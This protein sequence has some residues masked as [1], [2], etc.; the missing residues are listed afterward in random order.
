MLNVA[1]VGLGHYGQRLVESVNG[2]SQRVRVTHAVAPRPEKARDFAAAMGVSL[3]SDYA[4]VLADPSIAGVVSC[5][6]AHLHALHSLQAL[7][8]GKHVLGV[9]PMALAG[10]DARALQ[11]AAQARG[12]VMALGY[13]RC[14]MPNVARLREEIAAGALGELLHAQGSFCVHR[15]HRFKRGDWKGDPASAPPGGLADHMLY[16]SIETLGAVEEAFAVARSNVTDNDL[17]DCTAVLLR[18]RNGAS[19]SLAGVGETAQDH[20]FQ[21]FGSKG[22]AEARGSRGFRLRTVDGREAD[23]TLPGVDA[24]RLEMEAFAD[25]VTGARAFPVPLADAVH[26]V[27]ALE[28]IARSAREGRVMRVE[29]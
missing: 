6:P 16:L 21:V 12:L 10:A 15:Y 17:A 2:V 13:D 28:T 23:E 4:A 25:A 5:G 26:G 11:A 9:K 27:C 18:M 29:A 20:R 24:Q 1:M 8:A 3:T 19:A 22:W 14:F 7:E